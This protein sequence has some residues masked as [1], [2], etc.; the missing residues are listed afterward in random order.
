MH[1]SLGDGL[2]LLLTLAFILLFSPSIARL[3]KLPLGACEILLGSIAAALGALPSNPYFTLLANIGFYYLMFI[4]GMEVNLKKFFKSKARLIKLGLIYIVFL[5]AASFLAVQTIKLPWVFIVIIPVM[6]VGLLGVLYK[7]F[8]KDCKWLNASMVVATLAELASIV[9]LT[10]TAALSEKEGLGT[11]FLSILYLLGFLLLALFSFKFLRT[12]FWWYPQLKTLILPKGDKNEKD[13]R[14]C[15]S[16]FILIIALMSSLSLEIALGAFI[17]GAFLAT[18]FDHHEDL[19]HKLGSFGYGFLIPV[20]FIHVGSSFDLSLLLDLKILLAALGLSLFMIMLRLA[21]SFLF[22]K[23]L[24]F[25]GVL[26]FGLSH[27][28]P[29]TL[30]IAVATLSLEVGLVDIRVY[31]CLVLAA[32]L[33]TILAFSFIKAF[34]RK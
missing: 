10:I 32:V 25:K 15:M 19:E 23:S 24:G 7:D 30:L 28:M 13:I 3:S 5:Y 2:Y 8:G 12:L 4:A 1:A 27:S 26:L 9:G 17:A 6:S 29:L 11:L 20:F 18:F 33:E 21:G 34:A 22:I 31:S 16:I 14:F